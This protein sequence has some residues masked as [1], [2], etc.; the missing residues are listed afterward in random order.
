[1][2]WT[3]SACARVVVDVDEVRLSRILQC[4]A[5]LDERGVVGSQRRVE[6]HRD[7]ELLLAEHPRELCLLRC[8]VGRVGQLALADDERRSGG[9][10]LV[11]RRTNRLDLRGGGPAA[12]A[13]DPGTEPA[14]LGGELGEVVGGGVREEDTV[15]DKTRETDVRQR[16]E[17][18]SVPLHRRERVQ[19]CRRAGAV[20]RAH[21]GNTEAVQSL[22][23]GLGRDAAERLAVGVE[24]HQ[25]HD[26]E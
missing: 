1:M 26:R 4:A 18:E 13:D 24:G 23:R 8:S 15:A 14:R 3:P 22:G 2:F 21:G 12:T 16:R 17:D 20:V 6:L 19:C 10:V 25:G 5:G 9:A 7:D 11:D